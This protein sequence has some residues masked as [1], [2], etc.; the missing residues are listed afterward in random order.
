MACPNPLRLLLGAV[1]VAALSS[2]PATAVVTFG[3][4]DPAHNTTAPTGLLAGSGWQYLGNWNGFVGTQISANQFIT[5]AHVGG[6]VGG[7][8]IG[9]D[10][11]AYT[12]TAVATRNDLAVW[13]VSGQLPTAAPLYRGTSETSLDMVLFGR[14]VG[15]GAE[16][17]AP[18]STD[19]NRLRGWEWGSN[20]ALRWGTNR[21]D[22]AQSSYAGV[23]PA[24]IGDFDRNGG[25]EESTVSG[26][27]SGG[28]AFVRNGSEW[29]LA[30]IIFGVQ[31]TVRTT[32][33]G[34][35]LS[36]A[37]F[38]LGGLYNS[39]GNLITTDQSF[40][41][42]ASFVVSRVS[43]NQ[44]WIASQS[45]TQVPETSTWA[46]VLMAGVA[47]AGSWFRRRTS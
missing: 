37:I 45:A 44:A 33:S 42:P 38:D 40:D 31:S 18:S 28:A 41:I 46:A 1:S 8:F 12:T 30:G 34:P 32:P 25:A 29:Q 23:G 11:I 10:G 19:A 47:G 14:G 26:G 43:A 3:S 39:S 36:A 24:L 4:G 15:R 22:F 9:S 17:S 6:S 7:S 35:N 20:A 13:T 21:F 5:A 2:S 16:V 27:D